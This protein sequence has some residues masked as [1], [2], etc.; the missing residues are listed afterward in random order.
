[1]AEIVISEFMD[2]AS[3]DD[4]SAD[5]DVLFEPS[6]CE[7]PDQLH[8][9]L[10][11]A[12][13][14]IV[15]NRTQ[16]DQPLLDAAPR[17]EAIGRLGVGLDNIDVQACRARDIQVLPA[18][19]AADVSVAEYVLAMALILVRGVFFAT[20]AVLRGDWPR[21]RLIGRELAGK[22]M[23]L[24]GLGSI[25]RVVAHK[26]RALDMT[27]A[28]FDPYVSGDDPAWSEVERCLTLEALVER[29]DVVSVHVPLTPF[30][31]GLI[32]P[33]AF[34]RMKPGAVLIN[35]AR[36]GI[37][38]ETALADALRS[39]RLGG[40]ALDVFEQEPLSAEAAAR[41]QGVANLVLTPHVA[42]PTV[43]SNVRVSALIA[44]NVRRL[45]QDR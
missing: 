3:V 33:W 11:A 42:G 25:G 13:A 31:R 19:G 32:G 37:V 1:M 34:A 22:R 35:A 40:A 5:F 39:G 24:V 7:R 18:T 29:A 27:V 43:E 26:A 12:R 30:T 17:L 36:G 14:L 45:L 41:F 44:D 21:E 15:R 23:G 28:A 10:A 16:V 8:A 38:D 4:L 9:A 6:L 20:E 2:R